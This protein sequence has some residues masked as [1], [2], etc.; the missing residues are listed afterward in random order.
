MAPRSQVIRMNQQMQKSGEPADQPLPRPSMA[1]LVAIS[2]VNPL[3]LN[4]YLPSLAGM[5]AA[6]NTTSAQVQLTMSLYMAAVGV[7]QIFLGP[8]S[9]RY[10]RRPV[11]I[12][13]MAV[14]VV[15][16]LICLA[17]PDINTLIAGRIIQAM[18]G[19]AGLVL[20]RAIVRD[21]FERE[22]AASMIGYVTMGMAV[23]PMFAPAIGGALDG[24]FGWQG[25]FYLMLA[26]GVIILV[27]AWFDLHET[28]HNRT[29]G[30]GFGGLVASYRA[31]GS[32]R[33]FWAYAAT[34][35]FTSSVYFAFLGGAPF[36]AASVL[37]MS[38]V[39]M[40]LYFMLVAAGY[41][42]G[43]G[44]SGRYAQRIG[45]IRMITAGSLMPLVAVVLVAALFGAGVVHP[46]S[47]F[48]PML[49]VGLGNGLCLPSAIAG[50]VSVR[51]DLAGAASGLVGSMQI[52]LGAVSSALVAFLLSDGMYPATTWPLA[53]VMGVCVVMTLVAVVA[54]AILERRS[55]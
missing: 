38:P 54:A 45:V 26:I 19:C 32:E 36:I 13:G 44:L 43:N 4:I 20:G 51:P 6:F 27:A 21:L 16:T 49:L 41:I 48:L 1:I 3:A 25:G 22:R 7:T 17:A 30:Q 42:V 37:G 5:I 24:H 14:F 23:G 47:L 10:G 39:V 46:L 29:R 34:S 33:L 31:L 15:G 12:G 52:G 18:G 9:D 55:D 28:H 53:A 11:V 40:G 50:A 8:L 2:T 35:M